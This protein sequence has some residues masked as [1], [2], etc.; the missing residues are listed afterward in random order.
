MTGKSWQAL[1]IREMSKMMVKNMLY[2]PRIREKI[3]QILI[4]FDRCLNIF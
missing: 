3:L 4:K 2:D 1:A